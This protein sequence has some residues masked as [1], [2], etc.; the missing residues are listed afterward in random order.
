MASRLEKNPRITRVLGEWDEEEQVVKAFDFMLMIANNDLGVFL[1]INT[2]NTNI[3][4]ERPEYNNI[5][6][7]LGLWAS[8]STQIVEGLSYTTNTIKHLQEWDETAEL[9]FCTPNPF[10]DYFCD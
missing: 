4:Q 6:G 2:P 7:G 10:S 3:I 1:D 5:N 8:R 9:N